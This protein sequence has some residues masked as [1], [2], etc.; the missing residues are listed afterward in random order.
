MAFL[1]H[2]IQSESHSH[3]TSFKNFS[4]KYSNLGHIS[5]VPSNQRSHF[6]YTRGEY[7]MYITL[8]LGRHCIDWIIRVDYLT[9]LL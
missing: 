3:P 2:I 6:S 7:S 1:L 8:V 5:N 9:A 4:R